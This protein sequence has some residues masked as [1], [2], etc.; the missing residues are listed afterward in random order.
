MF[1]TGS[2]ACTLYC[3]QGKYDVKVCQI[4]LVKSKGKETK[5]EKNC[6]MA[7]HSQGRVNSP[8]KSGQMFKQRSRDY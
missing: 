7:D 1:P 5:C 4:N 6:L 3:L 2:A 8:K